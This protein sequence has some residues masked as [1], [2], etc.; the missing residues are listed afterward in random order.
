MSFSDTEERQQFADSLQRWLRQNYE[1]E[2]RRRVASSEDGVDADDWRALAELGVFSLIAP[3]WADGFNGDSID[4][5]LIMHY[6]GQALVVEPVLDTLVALD[7]LK[8]ARDSRDYIRDL[9]RAIAAGEARVSCAL[10]DR[11]SRYDISGGA[12]QA[13]Q[14]AGG[15]RLNGEKTLVAHGATADHFLL[16][17][18]LTGDARVPMLLCIPAHTEGL[19][20][21][22]YPTLD[23]KRASDLYAKNAFVPEQARLS[24][25]P[26]SLTR[27]EE[28]ATTAICAEALGVMEVLN[29]T[30][31]AYLKTRKQFGVPLASFQAL[32]HRCADMHMAREEA[33]ALTRAALLAMRDENAANRAKVISAA[34]VSV[35]RALR[36]I[37]QNAIHLHGGIG[38]TDELPVSHYFKR[39]TV[40]GRHFGDTDHH[41]SRFMRLTDAAFTGQL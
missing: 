28:L 8:G 17:T 21:R 10:F 35:N 40:I 39:A 29:T 22:T 41:L 19:A 23:G 14:V 25:D 34:K 15:W 33:R 20:T 13:L 11:N 27:C 36:Y 37:G 30:T 9:V 16:S 32:Q 1:F 3:D 24:C 7:A 5:G 4:I 6:L 18:R 2:H 31:F 12:M 38:L 26:A